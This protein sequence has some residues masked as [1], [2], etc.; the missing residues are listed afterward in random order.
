MSSIHEQLKEALLEFRQLQKVQHHFDELSRRHRAES[1]QIRKLAGLL[2][3]EERDVRQLEKTS[4]R[5]LFH[6]VL[7]NKER[8]IEKERQ[9][10]LQVALKYNGLVESV[11][12]MDYEMR[13]LEK[14]LVRYDQVEKRYN[15][16]IALREEELMQSDDAAG[17]EL[18]LLSRKI[19]RAHVLLK[20]IDEAIVAGKEAISVLRAMTKQ[21]EKA[22]D[23][24]QW[25][26]HGGG[27]VSGW[28]KHQAID[29]ARE[30]AVRARHAL[31]RFREE[32]LDVYEDA[33]IRVHLQVDRIN[34]F[35]DIF[36]DNLISDWVVQQK[37]RK[38]LD[39]VRGVNK[40]VSRAM[41]QLERD[42]P[43]VE[44]EIRDLE[45][46]REQVIVGDI[47]GV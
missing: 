34:R 37:I 30:I 26:V 42:V 18:M 44:Q 3:K 33:D 6:K 23:W 19:D 7:G 9:E 15:K 8:Q 20:D 35:T 38:A 47:S 39:N 45:V 24:G 46:K 31:F 36:F 1:A 41:A 32:M 4:V 40:Q 11:E 16:L 43:E 2:K 12:L 5:S 14:K 21:L 17:R 10:Y 27:N 22:R 28:S 25:D 29:R 13:V